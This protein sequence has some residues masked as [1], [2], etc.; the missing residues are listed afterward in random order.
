MA[1]ACLDIIFSLLAFGLSCECILW[2]RAVE[3]R[4]WIA[5]L[6]FIARTAVEFSRVRLSMFFSESVIELKLN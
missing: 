6:M 2:T 5:Y 4:P 1:R 3:G